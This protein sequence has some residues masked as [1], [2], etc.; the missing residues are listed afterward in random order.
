MSANSSVVK[1]SSPNR[2]PSAS[3]TRISSV[4]RGWTCQAS[5][6][7]ASG[8]GAISIGRSMADPQQA[9][10]GPLFIG[11]ARL[12]HGSVTTFRHQSQELILLAKYS[13]GLGLEATGFDDSALS[14]FRG[15]LV[16]GDR[17]DAL[18]SLVLARLKDVG[19]VRAGGR[20][21]TDATHVLACVRR[22]GPHRGCRRGPAGRVG[23]DRPGQ[24]RPHRGLGE[25]P[26]PGEDPAHPGASSSP[27]AWPRASTCWTPAT[28]APTTS[29]PEPEQAGGGTRL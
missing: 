3:R 10:C 21:R 18:L 25:R 15:R 14:E 9:W 26:A 1:S 28:P 22:P 5:A 2:G 20:Q 27:V 8:T 16:E 13:L 12:S 4:P 11:S 29:P 24:P 19:L 6:A 23:G 17:A 7:V